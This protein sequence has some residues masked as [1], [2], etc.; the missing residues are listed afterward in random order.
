MNL[1]VL[2]SLITLVSSKFPI[3]AH[4]DGAVL[5]IAASNEVAGF[6]AL[7]D[8]FK[9]QLQAAVQESIKGR[10]ATVCST[11]KADGETRAEHIATNTQALDEMKEKLE[12]K[13]KTTENF[14]KAQSDRRHLLVQSDLGS[15][16]D[17][18]DFVD[19]LEKEI[20]EPYL[21]GLSVSDENDV[22]VYHVEYKDELKSLVD[23]IQNVITTWNNQK[24]DLIEYAKG[25]STRNNCAAID[26]GDE[27]T[28]SKPPGVGSSIGSALISKLDAWLHESEEKS[29]EQ[30]VKDHISK[31]HDVITK[32]IPIVDVQLQS[33]EVKKIFDF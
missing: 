1:K 4:V 11:W 2:A 12:T 21:Q 24:Q 14:I 10:A 33:K 29:R 3:S 27:A 19:K 31:V 17:I 6:D 25:A 5:T 30:G 9:E 15:K 20:S 16:V 18:F 8:K 28:D 26:S 13:Y 32:N 23:V 7:T 22:F